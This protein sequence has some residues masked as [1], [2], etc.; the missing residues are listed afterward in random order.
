MLSSHQ[1][2]L[3]EMQI[4]DQ[5]IASAWM[6]E[7]TIDSPRFAG[8]GTLLALVIAPD[9]SVTLE[10]DPEEL[11]EDLFLVC[12]YCQIVDLP[13]STLLGEI[14]G[15]IRQ[16]ALT[17]VEVCR[18]MDHQWDGHM[19]TGTLTPEG[20]KALD[21]LYDA[22]ENLNILNPLARDRTLS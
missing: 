12:G 19:L 17:F 13:P 7:T 11:S 21:D 4:L 10:D 20:L 9:G 14:T 6:L 16:H 3:E 8:G 1:L 22:A 2:G 18:G 15:W 5:V